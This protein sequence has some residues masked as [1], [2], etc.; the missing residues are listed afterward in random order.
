MHLQLSRLPLELYRPIVEAI[1]H[2]P[3][4]LTL[5]AVCTLLRAEAERVLY[6][7]VELDPE[8][9]PLFCEFFAKYAGRI[10][11]HV[12]KCSLFLPGACATVD[13]F[14]EFTRRRPTKKRP[15]ASKRVE[16]GACIT[17]CIPL[18]KNLRTLSVSGQVAGVKLGGVLRG[19]RLALNSFAS[20]AP[21][22]KTTLD[23][24]ESQPH[25][26]ELTTLHSRLSSA[27]P[28]RKLSAKALPNLSVIRALTP[29]IA[30]ELAPR[31][32]VTHIETYVWGSD[33]CARV[34][35]RLALSR[36]PV[37]ALLVIQG[38]KLRAR[39][40]DDLARHLP[41]LEYMGECHF[42][43]SVASC[44]TALSKLHS[45]RTLVLSLQSLPI[46]CLED[47]RASLVAQL[48]R[49]C[50]SLHTIVFTIAL[51]PR[52]VW[53]RNV[54]GGKWEQVRR[55]AQSICCTLW[56]SA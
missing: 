41:S 55:P 3:A 54:Y 16:S 40:I 9:E 17:T 6:S 21:L 46:T 44:T 31:R 26:T 35:S 22:D 56:S 43:D 25:I 53:V 49:A 42:L 52:Q 50:P 30:T 24:L 11:R 51:M 47:D 32:P 14:E 23:F 45:L 15:C 4:L 13:Y 1:D 27:L 10:A 12:R 28:G 20:T 34:A 39:D 36:G 19:S 48:A 2:R 5:T 18:M 29:R 37:R 7:T 33:S 8:N 38:F